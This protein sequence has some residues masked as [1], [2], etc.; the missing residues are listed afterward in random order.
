M[1]FL[2]LRCNEIGDAGAAA[3]A[4]S[5]RTCMLEVLTLESNSITDTG[6]M[7]IAAAIGAEP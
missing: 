3:L 6:A 4:Q 1:T 2:I 5:L 7:S